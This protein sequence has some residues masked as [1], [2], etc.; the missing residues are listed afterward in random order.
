MKRTLCFVMAAVVLCLLAGCSAAPDRDNPEALIEYYLTAVQKKDY[1]AI[2]DMIP[3]KIQDYAIEKKI[4]ADKEDGLDYIYYAVNDYYWLVA[5][6][7]PKCDGF[8]VEILGTQT[9]DH[10]RVQQYL[11]NKGIRLVVEDALG[12]ACAVTAGGKTQE[13]SFF[14]IQ[15]GGAWYLTSVV[16]DDEVFEY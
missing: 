12:V 3:V 8:S 13:A 1:G 10:Q 15:T 6:E 2:W 7:L 16:G 9:E 14:L 11:A 5:L 4:I